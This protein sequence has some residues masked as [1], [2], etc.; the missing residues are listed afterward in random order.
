MSDWIAIPL[1]LLLAV[2]MLVFAQSDSV[3]PIPAW[4]SGLGGLGI[5]GA[6]LWYLI[7]K[8]LPQKDRD[9]CETIEKL[10]NRRAESE[11]VRH[12][13][14]ERLLETLAQLRESCAETRAATQ[15]VI[16]RVPADQASKERT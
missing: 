4:T 11:K 2:G 12:E 7:V 3:P 8:R 1:G 5:L 9:F 16:R 14:S 10:A 13:D 15:S 6:L